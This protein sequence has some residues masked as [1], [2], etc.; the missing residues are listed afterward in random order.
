MILSKIKFN[1]LT[2]LLLCL[3]ALPASL[4]AFEA[5]EAILLLKEGNAAFVNGN[6]SHLKTNITP[7]KRATLTASQAPYAIVLTCSDSRVP[8]EILFDKGLGEIFTIRVAGN[9]IAEHEIG[10]IEYAVEHLHTN[11]IVVLGHEKCGA[12]K[13][14]YDAHG[15]DTTELGPN[16]NSLISSIEPA[17]SAVLSADGG[18]PADTYAQAAQLEKCVVENAKMVM[19]SLIETSPVIKE[20]V[21]AGELKVVQAKY[22]LDDGKV[23][24]SMPTS[25]QYISYPTTNTSGRYTVSWTTVAGATAYVLEESSDNGATWGTPITVATASTYI[26]NKAN[27]SY[28]Y[29]VKTQKAGYHIDSAW[30]TGANAVTVTLPTIA[31]APSYID[32][33]TVT[34]TTGNFYVKWPA[35][36]GSTGY[37][38]EESVNSGA[39]GNAVTVTTA[40]PFLKGKANGTYKFRVKTLKSGLTD[41]PW[42][43][44]TK[45]LTVAKP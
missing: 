29:R 20:F 38:L 5:D 9:V 24:F 41:S 6:L 36:A 4:F 42:T 21:E 11:L 25:S 17:V 31:K 28:K 3:L 12:V 40:S 13:A 7:Q 2:G 23:T 44:G 35:V 18:K 27:G 37:V 33:G 14:T 43:T 10:S 19:D 30:T 1:L 8:P 26:T 22:D 16:L 15:T 34:N 39:W 45:S 32:Y